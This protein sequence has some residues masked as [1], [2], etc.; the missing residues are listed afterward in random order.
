MELVLLLTEQRGIGGMNVWKGSVKCMRIMCKTAI[1][2]KRVYILSNKHVTRREH[3]IIVFGFFSEESSFVNHHTEESLTWPPPHPPWP[4]SP[5]VP[6]QAWAS[7]PPFL[8]I[9]NPSRQ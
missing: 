4:S 9:A 7:S 5:A 6:R 2:V 1:R 3:S 8:V